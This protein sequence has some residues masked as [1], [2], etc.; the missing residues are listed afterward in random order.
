MITS[1]LASLPLFACNLQ[2][3][4]KFG[5]FLCLTIL[6]SWVFAN[7]GFMSIIATIGGDKQKPNADREGEK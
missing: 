2:F 5:T 4:A 6:F 1:V 7:F 3:F